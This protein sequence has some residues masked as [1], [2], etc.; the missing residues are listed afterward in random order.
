MDALNR[1]SSSPAAWRGRDARRAAL[2]PARPRRGI[3]PRALVLLSSLAAGGAE[4]VTV[5]FV[6]RLAETGRPVEFCTLT[7]RHDSSL[8]DELQRAGVPRRDLGAR[9]LLDPHACARYVHLLRQ[10]RIDVVHAHGQDAWILAGF[11]RRVTRVP[12]V[13]TR[14]VLDEPAGTWREALR[15]RCAIDAAR[16]ADVLVAPSAATA[17]RL[18]ELAGVPASTIQLLPNGVDLRQFASADLARRRE[19]LRQ[20]MGWA[21]HDRVVLLPAVLRR[22]K[23]HDVLIDALPH[24]ASAVPDARVVFAGGGEREVELRL[25][26]QPHARRLSVLGHRD[27]MPALLAACDLVVLPSLAEALPVALVEAAAAGRAIVASRVGGVPDIVEHGV[28]GLLVPANDP[29]ALAGA[30]EALL[31]DRAKA[32]AF[33]KAGQALAHRRFSLDAFVDASVAVWVSAIARGRVAA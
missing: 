27:D 31:V 25:A 26:A 23:G 7:D 4:R 28:T 17:R 18:A 16:Q 13:L 15:R 8:A 33:G 20:S 9:R 6:R 22:G 12:L 14:H 21:P 30:I 1:T 11:G 29:A 24:L 2:A 5:T 32:E 10:A 19:S 3:V